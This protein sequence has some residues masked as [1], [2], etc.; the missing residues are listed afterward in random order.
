M[1]NKQETNLLE[2]KDHNSTTR[3]NYLFISFQYNKQTS[4]I[5][6]VES[7]E[8]A[9]DTSLSAQEYWEAYHNCPEEKGRTFC[10]ELFL[11]SLFIHFLL[12]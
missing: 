1:F 2:Y 12:K 11:L 6:D 3:N 4:Q 8:S 7:D 9:L 5:M 10:G